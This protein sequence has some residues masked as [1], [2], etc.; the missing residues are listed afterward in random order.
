MGK[1]ILDV[2]VIF[3]EGKSKERSLNSKDTDWV[4][5]DTRCRIT[6]EITPATIHR[7]KKATRQPAK[8]D[9]YCFFTL[10]QI[11]PKK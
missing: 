6:T 1:G 5:M 4:V 11:S 10:N 9:E 3:N 2:G 8:Q 7:L